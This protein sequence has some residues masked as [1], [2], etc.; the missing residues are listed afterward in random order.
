MGIILD[1][2]DHQVA[3]ARV[4]VTLKR[5]TGPRRA[6]KI[7]AAETAGKGYRP[8]LRQVSVVPD[9]P[10]S[11]PRAIRVIFQ[12]PIPPAAALELPGLYP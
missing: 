11:Q 8:D 7:A 6:N 2:A 3:N 9:L 12:L 5:G 1:H 4:G 10:L